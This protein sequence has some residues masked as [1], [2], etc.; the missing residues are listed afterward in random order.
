MSSKGSVEINGIWYAENVTDIQIKHGD[1]IGIGCMIT[2]ITQADKTFYKARI[3][4]LPVSKTRGIMALLNIEI[5][6]LMA[7][8]HFFYG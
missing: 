2:E 7:K 6:H 8:N 3:L 5:G 4:K 1:R